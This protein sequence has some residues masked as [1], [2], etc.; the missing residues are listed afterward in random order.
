MIWERKSKSFSQDD[1]YLTEWLIDLEPNEIWHYLN[2][3]PSIPRIRES[4]L[5]PVYTIKGLSITFRSLYY[6]TQ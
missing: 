3:T 2:P 1:L 5:H 4:L 6:G